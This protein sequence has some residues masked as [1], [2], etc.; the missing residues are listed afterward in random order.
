MSYF[1]IAVQV[2]YYSEKILGFTTLMLN[3]GCAFYNPYYLQTLGSS[4]EN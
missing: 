3:P 2:T 4:F 1:N